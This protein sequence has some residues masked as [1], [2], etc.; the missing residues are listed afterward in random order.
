MR[1]VLVRQRITHHIGQQTHHRLDHHQS[2]RLPA[3]QDV[4]A[5]RNLFDAHPGGG[6]IGHPLVDAFV[7]AAGEHQVL[8]LRPP[9]SVG[10]GEQPAGRRRQHQK[11]CL[12]AYLVERL[13]PDRSLHHH[14]GPAAVRRVVD[15]MVD[16]V[17]PAPEIVHGKV[18]DAGLDCLARQ[19]LP[20]RI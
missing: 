6:V 3:G 18:D 14:A 16:V 11:R 10:L 20:H 4:V 2:S 1:I 17:G 7:A 8:L 12:R 19:R 5:D 9:L 15:G 13:T